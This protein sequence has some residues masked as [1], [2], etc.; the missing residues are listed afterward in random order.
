MARIS[1]KSDAG[2][3]LEPL[4]VVIRASRK[5]RGLSQEALADA[6]GIDRSHMGKIER[7]ERN[8]T[9]LNLCR[10]AD[11]LETKASALLLEAGL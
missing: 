4:G 6:A 9:L 2:R 11:A 8:V 1:G 5:E 10:I 3:L 7:G